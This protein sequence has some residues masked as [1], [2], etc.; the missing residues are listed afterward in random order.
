MNKLRKH[1]VCSS[2]AY[3]YSNDLSDLHKVLVSVAGN[4]N[5]TQ[6]E[7]FSCYHSSKQFFHI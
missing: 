3:I 5:S 7:K 4:I 2:L 6:N 1:T